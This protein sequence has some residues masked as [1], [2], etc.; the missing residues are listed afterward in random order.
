MFMGALPSLLSLKASLGPSLLLL[1]SSDITLILSDS[2][3]AA[4]LAR[5]ILPL[6]VTCAR[7]RYF[8]AWFDWCCLLPSTWLWPG[9]GSVS[10]PLGTG[11]PA[12]LGL[13]AISGINGIAP[14]YG[15]FL[16]IPMKGGG[17]IMPGGG[18]PI[19]GM[20]LGIGK[21]ILAV[22]GIFAMSAFMSISSPGFPAAFAAIFFII[23]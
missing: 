15:G 11:I 9:V 14:G 13:N 20:F 6:R 8:G 3:S 10:P 12:A 2:S 22:G 17:N 19:I 23:F 7:L 4:T 1:S 5:F 18:I 16:D 21:G